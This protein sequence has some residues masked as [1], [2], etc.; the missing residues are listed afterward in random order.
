MAYTPEL[1]KVYSGILRR[2]AWTYGIP[3]TKALEGIFD[4][5]TTYM[6]SKKVCVACKDKGFCAQCPFNPSN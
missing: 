3:M 5:A 6:D 1:T 2:I 4:Y